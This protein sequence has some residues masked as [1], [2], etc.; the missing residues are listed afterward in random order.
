MYSIATDPGNNRILVTFTKDFDYE[1]DDLIAELKGAIA[2][3]KRTDGTFDIL[4]DF[5]DVSVMPQDHADI[6]EG[7]LQWLS[8]NGLRKSANV[9]KSLIQRMQVNR[10]SGNNEKIG[11]FEF[12]S[13]A[14]KWLAQ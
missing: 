9:M 1:A 10:V 11:V 8:D 7:F 3:V 13:E 5:T 6:S 14:E 12:R 4:S 2:A